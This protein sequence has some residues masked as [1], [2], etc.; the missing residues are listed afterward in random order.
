MVADPINR[1]H[2]QPH[3]LGVFRQSIHRKVVAHATIAVDVAFVSEGLHQ[4]R[5]PHGHAHSNPNRQIGISFWRKPSLVTRVQF[6]S[7][8]DQPL[9]KSL[10][11]ARKRDVSVTTFLL[12][13]LANHLLQAKA[14][15]EARPSGICNKA[16]HHLGRMI[17]DGN[18]QQPLHQSPEDAGQGAQLWECKLVKLHA[19]DH[20]ED[21]AWFAVD[22]QHGSHDRPSRD[23]GQR[24]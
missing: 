15:V 18:P 13:L 19:L 23:A 10:L 2:H 24:L 6:T 16:L 9:A 7:Q 22:C 20:L 3:A 1:S 5:H 21:L 14:A 12:K 17:A 4:P 8:D 11:H